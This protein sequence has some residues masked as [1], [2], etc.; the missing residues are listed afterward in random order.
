MGLWKFLCT[1]AHAVGKIKD[2]A[3]RYHEKHSALDAGRREDPAG[4]SLKSD[5]HG[6]QQ[7]LRLPIETQKFGEEKLEG[8][9]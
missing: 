1:S 3:N 9:K 4:W 6:P 2:S 5:T 7:R 8:R